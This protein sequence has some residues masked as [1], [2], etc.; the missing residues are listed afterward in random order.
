MNKE[1]EKQYKNYIAEQAPDMWD[2][3]EAGLKEKKHE[4]RRLEEGNTD[5]KEQAHTGR[6]Q[7]VLKWRKA[8]AVLVPAAAVFLCFLAYEILTENHRKAND[9]TAD[10]GM[11]FEENGFAQSPYPEENP[12]Y[13]DR[14]EGA[15]MADT[16]EH[17]AGAGAWEAGAA[18]EIAAEAEKD[19]GEIAGENITEDKGFLCV[20]V[21]IAE[22]GVTAESEYDAIY[23]AEIE[24]VVEKPEVPA[25][26]EVSEGTEIYFYTGEDTDTTEGETPETGKEYEVILEPVF[27]EENYFAKKIKFIP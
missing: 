9:M 7:S 4:K 26:E 16:P 10:H 3:I 25:F 27:G 21:K 13:A 15:D 6:G 5:R 1:F 14:T 20:R 11:D 17:A 22:A 19:A 24:E 8:A 23:L 12:D 2:R 18:E